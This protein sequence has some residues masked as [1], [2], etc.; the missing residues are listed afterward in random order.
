MATIMSP[1]EIDYAGGDG[2]DVVSDCNECRATA[3][4]LAANARLAVQSN[5]ASLTAPGD[6]P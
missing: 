3:V 5:D 1:S 4:P 2:N 6:E